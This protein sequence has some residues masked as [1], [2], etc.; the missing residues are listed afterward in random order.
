MVLS[1]DRDSQETRH[2]V[3]VDNVGVICSNAGIVAPRIKE[4][5]ESFER[6]GL[7]VHEQELPPGDG[8]PRSGYQRLRNRLE[9]L[10]R[11]TQAGSSAI[12][13]QRLGT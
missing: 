10:P 12:C 5:V 13:G 11:Y 1:L 9:Y 8:T 2:Y 4:I 3:C 6:Q 7:L